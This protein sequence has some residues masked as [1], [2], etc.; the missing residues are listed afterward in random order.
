VGDPLQVIQEAG[1]AACSM[2]RAKEGDREQR[3]IE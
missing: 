1:S 2:C 3:H